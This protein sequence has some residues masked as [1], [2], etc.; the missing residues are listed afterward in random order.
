MDTYGYGRRRLS[1]TV[2]PFNNN[3]STVNWGTSN[4]NVVTVTDGVLTAVGVGSA[5]VYATT[6]NFVSDQ[7]TPDLKASVSVTVGQALYKK[8]T[9]IPTSAEAANQADDCLTSGSVTVSSTGS[10][11]NDKEALQLSGGKTATITVSGYAGMKI[12]G[13]DLVMSSNG[14]AG[15][16]SLTVTAGSTQIYEI[17]TAAFSD[18]TWNGAYDALACDIYKDSTD[19]VVSGSETIV[20]E[21]SATVNSLYIHSV[22][23]RYLD[24]S[25][26]QWCENFLTQI[27][28]DGGNPGSITDDSNWDDLGI[29]FLDLDED[30]RDIAANANADKTSASVIEQAM[31]RYDLILRKYGIGTGTGQHEDFIGRFGV[32]KVNGPLNASR[33][34]FDSNSNGST[35][36]IIVVSLVSITSLGVLLVI[37]RK[38]GLTK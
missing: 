36:I 22:S 7:T 32:G 1:A 13:I 6:G 4:P 14:N 31:A 15:T 30:L 16:G 8:A 28:C 37:K 17:E 33:I 21:F 27:T 5:T 24:Y 11:S 20:F 2:E 12:T 18:A 35:A 26:E 19:Y 25:L 34:S 3:D 29:A 38:R 9:F 23:L 10:Y